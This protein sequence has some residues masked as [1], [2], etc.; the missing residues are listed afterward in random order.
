MLQRI[1]LFF[2]GL[3]AASSLAVAMTL[4]GL[5]P[6]PP[7]PPA[8]PATPVV[9]DAADAPVTTSEPT[10]STASTQTDIVYV[11]P[12]PTPKTVRIVR[13]APVPTSPPRPVIVQRVVT[14]KG[15][16]EA[17]RGEADGGDGGE[18]D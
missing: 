13:R 9:V 12:A 15:G 14:S 16:G 8:S 1:A 5:A 7:A 2:A 6:T 10:A 17:D 18:S 11:K 4:A 3:A